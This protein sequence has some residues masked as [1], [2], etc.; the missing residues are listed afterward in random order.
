MRKLVKV[1]AMSLIVTGGAALSGCATIT[2]GT[3]QSIQVDSTPAKALVKLNGATFGNTPTQ[4]NLARKTKTATV[5]IQLA[6]FETHKIELDRKVNGWVWGNVA[7]GGL[8]GLAID[9]TTG[10]M[11]SYKLPKD[12]G[13]VEI[14]AAGKKAPSGADLWI[15]VVLKPQQKWSKVGQM[16]PV[17]S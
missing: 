8:I 17:S 6:G 14:P 1:F 11:Y 13:I 2:S 12:S 16:V 9:A 5:E 7:F 15:N 4:I 3:D 10:A